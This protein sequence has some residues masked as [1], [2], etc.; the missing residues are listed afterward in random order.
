[1]SLNS[2]LLRTLMTCQ[3]LTEAKFFTKQNP[4]DI[5]EINRIQ[6]A[7]SSN[8]GCHFTIPLDKHFLKTSIAVC[9]S[10]TTEIYAQ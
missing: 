9:S 10:F 3:E 2:I 8:M 1:M 6:A 4:T 5:P 7:S